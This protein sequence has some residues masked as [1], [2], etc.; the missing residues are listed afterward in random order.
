MTKV[1]LD[2]NILIDW[3]V[4]REPFSYYASKVI[5]FTAEKEIESF[6]SALTLANTY[7]LISKELSKKVAN[8]FL[9]DSR[10]LFRFTDMPGKVITLS[11]ED[12]YKDFEDDL[13]YYTAVEHKL[14]Y[15]ITRNKKDF[16]SENIHI[17]DAEEFV[18]MKRNGR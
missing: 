9:R 10:R 13:H 17:V 4:D 18:Q 14:D 11:I 16:K 1:Y 6:V 8:E 2:C 5:D 15:L 7:Y 12:R 3:L